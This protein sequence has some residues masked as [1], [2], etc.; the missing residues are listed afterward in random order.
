MSGGGVLGLCGSYLGVAAGRD[1]GVQDVWWIELP[2]P[3][4]QEP[5]VGG[6]V[7]SI[8]SVL[9]LPARRGHSKRREEAAAGKRRRW[10]PA[11]KRARR[12]G[13]RPSARVAGWGR[14]DTRRT[15]K[16]YA[17]GPS[18]GGASDASLTAGLAAEPHFRSTVDFQAQFPSLAQASQ[19]KRNAVDPAAL[20]EATLALF[21]LR[22]DGDAR[23][24][25]L[26]GVGTTLRDALR[27]RYTDELQNRPIAARVTGVDD[28]EVL[29]D[30]ERDVM[31]EQ[32]RGWL[33]T[34]LTAWMA[35]IYPVVDKEVWLG[36]RLGG[37]A[38]DLLLLADAIGLNAFAWDVE[39][40]VQ[41]F[42]RLDIV[43]ST[44]PGLLVL[45]SLYA[46]GMGFREPDR[47]PVPAGMA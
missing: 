6:A 13:R 32:L 16:P 10:R 3:R 40:D 39:P 33:S 27:D 31:I 25:Y 19:E 43:A 2:G 4:R 47:V 11:T 15:W 23:E 1:W 21:L 42:E 38:I 30:R 26:A 28:A 36:D 46:I 7:E 35:E 41:P 34:E 18:A 24:Q 44:E 22:E 5:D 17:A 8:L 20:W 29:A 45:A 14:T 9:L 37:G 12:A